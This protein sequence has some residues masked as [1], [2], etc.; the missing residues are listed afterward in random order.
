M[1]VIVELPKTKAG[2]TTVL[3][4]VELLTKMPHFH[5]LE[6][7]PTSKKLATI[8][9]ST[10]VNHHGLPTI[11]ITD[12]GSQFLSNFWKGIGKAL[13]IDLRPSSS[14]HPQTDGQTER[15]N[16]ALEQ[17]LRCQLMYNT[18]EGA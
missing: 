15:V 2:N 12:R 14:H 9:L 1:D 18:V 5:P 11:I 7:L 8:F 16:Q 6:G 4:I 10:I 13:H 3:V 17:Y